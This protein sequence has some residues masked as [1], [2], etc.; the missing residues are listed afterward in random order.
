MNLELSGVWTLVAALVTIEFGK[1]LNKW[2]PWLERGNIPPAVSAGLVLSLVLAGLRAGG[3]L[4]VKF[5]TAPRDVLL[6]VFF[7]SLGFGAHLGRLLSAG[8]GT[9][10]I[11]LAITLVVLG[12]NF[13]GIALA[14]A[15]GRPGGLGLFMGSIAFAGGHGTAVAWADS[16]EAAALPGALEIGLGAATLGLVL[17][18]LVAGPV[19]VWLATRKV[20]ETRGATVFSK[21]EEAGPMREP[22]F[23]SDRWL[24]SLLWI[25]LCVALGPILRDW[26]AGQGFKVPTF[27]A[28]LL[29]GVVI[30]N[31]ADAARKPLDTEVTD[32]VGT[33]ALRIFL[34]IAMLALDWASLVKDLPM[35][36]T[37]AVAQVAVTV[38][39][40]V[41]VVYLLFGRDRDAAA[42][43]GGF[44]GF[45]L[46][47]MPVGL[48][49]MRRLNTRFGET[50]RALLAI[51]LAASLYTDTANAL[52]IAAL[53]RWLGG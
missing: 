6:L 40:G 22:A 30:T 19:A 26:A 41:V 37:A 39:V 47:A 8:K 53:F 16:A 50:P 21:G 36:L 42:A 29:T 52:I 10:V 12:Q 2:L 17:G 18:G 44:I 48:A 49:V 15:F 35:L 33:V 14:E 13:A 24:P 11:V 31:I 20:A 27:L 51:T 7:A 1:R 43:T 5:S 23:S 25:C 4:D 32:L 45:S 9:M 46:G 38:V 3:W 34:A 28:V